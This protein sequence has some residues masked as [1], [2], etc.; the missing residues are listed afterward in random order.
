MNSFI[1]TFISS[2]GGEK[3]NLYW[4]MKYSETKIRPESPYVMKRGNEM[5]LD[6]IKVHKQDPR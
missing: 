3:C 4:V 5:P 6:N 2:H 1:Q